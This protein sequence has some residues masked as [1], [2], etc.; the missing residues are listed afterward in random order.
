MVRDNSPNSPRRDKS[1]FDFSTLS[2]DKCPHA[3]N[4]ERKFRLL[5]YLFHCHFYKLSLASP[6]APGREPVFLDPRAAA[7]KDVDK[8]LKSILCD[9]FSGSG[10][11]RAQ[12]SG[13]ARSRRAGSLQEIRMF[14]KEVKTNKLTI[15]YLRILG[16]ML[17]FGFVTTM[18]QIQSLV[19]L[20]V[21]TL[22]GRTDIRAR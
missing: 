3:A 13:F 12:T 11:G 22:D 17:K 15:A 2:A 9:D 21:K 10:L 8:V 20:L 4:T 7:S 16:F 5:E 19:F 14:T 6:A 1:A 18:P